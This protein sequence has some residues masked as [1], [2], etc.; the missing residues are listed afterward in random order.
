[1]RADDMVPEPFFPNTLPKK[2][3]TPPEELVWSVDFEESS[4][5][6]EALAPV[7]DPAMS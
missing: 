7:D 3:R 6:L 5:R 4:V 2:L 1:M